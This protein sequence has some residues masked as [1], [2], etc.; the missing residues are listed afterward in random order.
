M[1]EKKKRT[2]ASKKRATTTT[3]KTTAKKGTATRKPANKKTTPAVKK[4][5]PK[6][7]ELAKVE[8]PEVKVEEPKEEKLEKTI[9][10]DGKQNKNLKE[11][12]EKLEEEN[13][14]VENKVIKRS[15]ARKVI[16]AILSVAMVIIAAAAAAYVISQ[17]RINKKN[18]ELN[19]QT[20]GS[21]IR[22]KVQDQKK[23]NNIDVS[24][25]KAEQTQNYE[26][27]TDITLSEF[28]AMIL[29][30]KDTVVLVASSSCAA[31]IAFEPTIDEVF[32]DEDMMV[33]RLDIHS[34]TQEEETRFRTYYAYT[35]TPTL[36]VVK[37]GV[38]TAD[39]GKSGAVKKEALVEWVE[40]NIK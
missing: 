39:T 1:E 3:K 10:F 37:N 32:H 24:V 38:V 22:A 20:T 11:V 21:D 18:S 35:I 28:E 25:K 7:V 33:Y 6:K 14:V 4:S 19:D 15:R 17:A 12:V 8:K 34:M 29:D 40:D 36:F 16:I 9:I 30:G 5:A 31:S 26:N 23:K 13:V 2:Q 27:I